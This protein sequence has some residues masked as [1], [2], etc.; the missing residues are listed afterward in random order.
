MKKNFAPPSPPDYV[1][2]LLFKV[3][4]TTDAVNNGIEF[5]FSM[6]LSSKWNITTNKQMAEGRKLIHTKSKQSLRYYHDL[7]V[8]F[9][10]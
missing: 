3:F 9:I 4:Q 8:L 2:A 10:Y 7:D 6:P 1:S 5:D